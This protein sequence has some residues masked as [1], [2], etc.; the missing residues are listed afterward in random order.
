MASQTDVRLVTTTFICRAED[1][2][3]AFRR[4]CERVEGL[5][6]SVVTHSLAPRPCADADRAF[7]LWNLRTEAAYE[8]Q[9]DPEGMDLYQLRTIVRVDPTID[10]DEEASEQLANHFFL[11]DLEDNDP[12]PST[13]DGF[14]PLTLRH[15]PADGMR[16]ANVYFLSRSD[17]ERRVAALYQGAI[18][19]LDPAAHTQLEPFD[20]LSNPGAIGPLWVRDAALNVSGG[21]D[22]WYSP[23]KDAWVGH[24]FTSASDEEI[25]AVLQ[26]DVGE[27][28]VLAR[29]EVLP[30]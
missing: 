25:N 2:D 27:K 7:E 29:V 23:G 28:A 26:E 20:V 13:L 17:N 16:V 3:T 9:S 10:D 18:E 1:L 12:Y 11:S 30:F 22:G 5:G 6:E 14:E 15:A 21:G 19:R 24:I 8:G 4:Y